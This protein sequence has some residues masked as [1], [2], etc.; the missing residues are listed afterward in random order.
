MKWLL[1]R[2]NSSCRRR[3]EPKREKLLNQKFDETTGQIYFETT[4]PAQ[5]SDDRE[6][7]RNSCVLLGPSDQ[8]S[9]LYVQYVRS[10]KRSGADGDLGEYHNYLDR[11]SAL[12]T[13]SLKGSRSLQDTAIECVIQNISDITP[14]AIECLPSSVVRRLWY[15]VNRR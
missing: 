15:L 14:E 12:G 3:V 1:P 6:W 11:V 4:A 8:D 5:R 9:E 13:S 2:H 10:W 7:A